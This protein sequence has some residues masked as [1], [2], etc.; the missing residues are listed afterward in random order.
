MIK[1]WIYRSIGIT[2]VAI[3]WHWQSHVFNYVG[4]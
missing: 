4:K 2:R 3:K 1:K